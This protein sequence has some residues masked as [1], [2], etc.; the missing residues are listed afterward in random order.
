MKGR[1]F[2]ASAPPAPRPMYYGLIAGRRPPDIKHRLR[3]LLGPDL[4]TPAAFR[5]LHEHR[6]SP[7][8]LVPATHHSGA[9]LAAHD[10]RRFF[11]GRDDE[12]TLR[13]R[14]QVFGNAL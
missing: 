3:G 11:H 13:T 5:E 2:F 14:P 8:R 10:E 7:A 1:R 4:Q 12:H 9:V 6:V